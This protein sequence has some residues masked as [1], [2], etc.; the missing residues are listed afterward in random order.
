M[1]AEPSE[2]CYTTPVRGQ[3]T[4]DR[5]SSTAGTHR[6]LGNTAASRGG[7]NSSARNCQGKHITG[8]EQPS[9]LCHTHRVDIQAIANKGGFS[10]HCAATPEHAGAVR[11]HS[12]AQGSPEATQRRAEAPRKAQE[13][14]T[15]RRRGPRGIP[16]AVT[17]TALGTAPTAF[18]LYVERW[19][20]AWGLRS[21]ENGTQSRVEPSGTAPSRT[22][23]APNRAGPST[24]RPAPAAAPPHVAKRPRRARTAPH[25]SAEEATAAAG[26]PRSSGRGPGPA[27]TSRTTAAR[28][29]YRAPAGRRRGRGSPAGTAAR[30]PA[31]RPGR[32]T[33]RC[34][35]ARNARS[36]TRPAPPLP[37]LP[38]S[39]SASPPSRPGGGHR[40]RAELRASARPLPPASQN[41][42]AGG[43]LKDGAAL[44]APPSRTVNSEHAQSA[45]RAIRAPHSPPWGEWAG[46]ASCRDVG[47]F[48][49]GRK[50]KKGWLFCFRK[51][52]DCLPS[53]KERPSAGLMVRSQGF[54]LLM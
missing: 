46:S 43:S 42:C 26:G 28:R 49:K 14:P 37:R 35:A 53:P 31:R 2:K 39:S 5:T 21:G 32:P 1:D 27:L 40:Q 3:T 13:D 9:T 47:A 34:A 12:M 17:H 24:A 23:G 18:P 11:A 10:W 19:K 6:A 54:I 20:E 8:R 52:R 36:R 4:S 30:R 7:L 22:E 16:H 50:K 25:R 29:R 41:A 45:A 51:S 33:S 48:L 38:P 44:A 15:E